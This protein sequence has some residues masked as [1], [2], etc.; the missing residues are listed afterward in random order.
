MLFLLIKWGIR[1]KSVVI[2]G[3]LKILECLKKSSA[4]LPCSIHNECSLIP[5]IERCFTQSN[6]HTSNKDFSFTVFEVLG[7]SFLD[8]HHPNSL[9]NKLT[10]LQ[11]GN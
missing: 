1:K 2:W 4:P 7:L 8:T 3:N 5:P 10:M 6:K 11:R 9:A